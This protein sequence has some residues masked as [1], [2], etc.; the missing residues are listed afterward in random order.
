MGRQD[1]KHITCTWK[2]N[3]I[4]PMWCGKFHKLLKKLKLT[5]SFARFLF[6]R[7]MK[8][9]PFNVLYISVFCGLGFLNSLEDY[10]DLKSYKVEY[11]CDGVCCV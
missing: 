3:E 1:L 10:N 5:S 8:I 7:H 11:R 6:C 2:R 4:I 9:G